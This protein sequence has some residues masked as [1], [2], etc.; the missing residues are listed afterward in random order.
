MQE[1]DKLHESRLARGE[2]AVTIDEVCNIIRARYLPG[3][4]M[5]D[6]ARYRLLRGLATALTSSVPV[7]DGR[8]GARMPPCH[9]CMHAVASA[10]SGSTVSGQ[11]VSRAPG[12]VVPGHHRDLP[13]QAV[14]YPMC[15][16]DT[17]DA[18]LPLPCHAMP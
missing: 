16:C 9:G 4:D 10:A 5:A 7:S 6:R 1:M 17:T 15:L 13:V 8:H 14:R 11:A 3:I 18:T 2:G 12:A